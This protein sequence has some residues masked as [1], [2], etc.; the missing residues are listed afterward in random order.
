MRQESRNVSKRKKGRRERMAKDKDPQQDTMSCRTATRGD[1]RNQD[2]LLRLPRELRDEIYDYLLASGH[3]QI[4]T[5]SRQ[6]SQEAVESLYREAV[7][8]MYVNSA[9]GHR[10]I[11]PSEEVA[12]QIQNLN[13]QWDMSN[14]DCSRNACDIIDFCQKRPATRRTCHVMLEFDAHR[15]ALLNAT[16]ISALRSL[17]IFQKVVFTTTMTSSTWVTSG[18]RLAR[19]RRRIPGMFRTLSDELGL[20]LGPADQ[21]GDADIRC[22]VF[23][24]SKM[25][26][27][28]FDELPPSNRSY[29][30]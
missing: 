10:N 18:A 2:T 6:L 25:L 21:R 3:F 11:K 24:P 12:H 15:A 19:L 14:F 13:L 22:L 30:W 26:E 20:A 27:K 8:R 23:H 4:L 9:D 28:R 16:D 5:T 1:P 17:R 7:Y 29:G